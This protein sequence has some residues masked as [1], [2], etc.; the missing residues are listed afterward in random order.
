VPSGSSTSFFSAPGPSLAPQ[1][2]LFFSGCFPFSPRLSLEHLDISSISLATGRKVFFRS[3][4][5]CRKRNV[6]GEYPFRFQS[7][8]VP[9]PK[10]PPPTTPLLDSP[11][12]A[13]PCHKERLPRRDAC[14]LFF[15]PCLPTP[16]S[17][18]S[19][20]CSKSSNLSHVKSLYRADIQPL[21]SPL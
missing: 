5:I 9:L 19:S 16:P 17:G 18:N 11:L 15:S 20:F 1:K 4:S 2:S 8:Q 13:C 21:P 6:P 12:P 7:P 3:C 10:G 14:L